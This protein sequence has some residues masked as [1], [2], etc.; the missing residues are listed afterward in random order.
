M[1]AVI[2]HRNTKISEAALWKTSIFK[3]YI[4][5]TDYKPYVTN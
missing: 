2:E 4:Q 3:W 1:K 5:K